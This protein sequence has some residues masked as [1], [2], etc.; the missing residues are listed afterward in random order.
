[1]KDA[2]IV[3]KFNTNAMLHPNMFVTPP[4]LNNLAQPQGHSVSS[5]IPENKLPD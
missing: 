3:R 4:Y 2:S 1:M 5:Q